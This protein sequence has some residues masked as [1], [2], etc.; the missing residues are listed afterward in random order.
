MIVGL[1][2]DFGWQ[3]VVVPDYGMVFHR[4]SGCLHIQRFYFVSKRHG[5]GSLLGIRMPCT[6]SSNELTGRGTIFGSLCVTSSSSST[7]VMSPFILQIR[8]LREHSP[9][10][11]PS[12]PTS[13]IPTSRA[14]SLHHGFRLSSERFDCPNHP[15]PSDGMSSFN[16]NAQGFDQLQKRTL[17]A[18]SVY[19]A[20]C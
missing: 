17:V 19:G 11:R 4:T 6:S 3:P 16:I 14:L 7:L 5:R 10:F 2:Y 15:N 13:P 18:Q 8:G 20:A 9:R 1:L 12:T